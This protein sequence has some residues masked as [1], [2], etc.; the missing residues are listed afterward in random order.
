MVMGVVDQV[1]DEL[2]ASSVLSFFF[3][4]LISF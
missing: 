2:Q 4:R 3:Y 1:S